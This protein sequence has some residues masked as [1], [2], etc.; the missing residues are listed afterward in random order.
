MH[1]SLVY[2]YLRVWSGAV[3]GALNVQVAMQ[4]M[5]SAAA[6]GASIASFNAVALANP[7]QFVATNLH[8]WQFAGADATLSYCAMALYLSMS[9][10]SALIMA[11][12]GPLEDAKV[13]YYDR[14]S[15]K[16]LHMG[17]GAIIPSF[18][19]VVSLVWL[20]LSLSASQF[21]SY[22]AFVWLAMSGFGAV[23]LFNSHMF[24]KALGGMASILIFCISTAS[25]SA[26]LPYELMDPFFQ[27]G[28]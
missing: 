15:L 6:S 25:S 19:P 8:T 10:H 7:V 22:W 17:F 24:G 5:A 20:G 18:F 3:L 23:S 2:S 12:H 4:A 26:S 14:L 16:I 9:A 27:I 13:L 11:S 21:F 28:N 1:G